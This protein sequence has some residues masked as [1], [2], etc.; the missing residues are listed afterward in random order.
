MTV[1]SANDNSDPLQLC[2]TAQ[3]QICID[4]VKLGL[5]EAPG[6]L[7]ID[8]LPGTARHYHWQRQPRRQGSAPDPTNYI[9]PKIYSSLML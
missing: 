3:P 1:A 6:W 9:F 2:C 8:F 5:I 4:Q 7:T